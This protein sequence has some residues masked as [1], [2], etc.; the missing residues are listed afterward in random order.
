MVYARGPGEDWDRI[1]TTS[2]DDGW[3]WNNLQQFV[4]KVITYLLVQ[5]DLMF[6]FS[7]ILE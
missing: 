6:R 2:G 3:S 4:F 7:F 5:P 1:A